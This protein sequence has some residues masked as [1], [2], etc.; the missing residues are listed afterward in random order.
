MVILGAA[1]VHLGIPYA[2]LEKAIRQMFA[3]KGDDVININIAAL[4]AG[5]DVATK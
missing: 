1:S 2:E 5:H 3:K 4:K